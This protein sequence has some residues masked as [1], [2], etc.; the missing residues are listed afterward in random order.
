[1]TSDSVDP[2]PSKRTT[3]ATLIQ[4]LTR[5]LEAVNHDFDAAELAGKCVEQSLRPAASESVSADEAVIERLDVLA[6]V[7]H[8][9]G[10]RTHTAVATVSEALRVL[11][12]GQPLAA[13]DQLGRRWCVFSLGRRGR[14]EVRSIGA[15]FQGS[16]DQEIHLK[17]ATEKDILSLLG[18]QGEDE[19]HW[20]VASSA[21]PNAAATAADSGKAMTNFQR[22]RRLLAPER[23]DI[24]AVVIFAITIGVFNLATPIA[25]QAIVNL[26]AQGGTIQPLVS[27]V[28][29]LALALAFVAVLVGI[30][31]WVV[32]LIQRRLLVRAVA[33]LAARIPR[34]ESHEYDT[35]FGPE[36]INRFFDVL[37]VQKA[38]TKLL[39][40]ALSVLLGVIVGLTVL[41]FYH[42]FLLAFDVVLL[43]VIA[44]IV[45]GPLRRGERTAIL[46]SSAKYKVAAW[47][48]E[49][50]RSPLTFRTSGADTWI[51]EKTDSLS[52]DWLAAREGHFKTL[53]SQIVGALALLVV[54]ST[55]LLAIGGY[56]VLQGSLTL[57]QLVAAELIVSVVVVS[58]AKLGKNMETWYDLMAAVAKVGSLL[59]LPIESSHGEHYAQAKR[60]LSAPTSGDGMSGGQTVGRKLELLGVSYK[61]A[62][63]PTQFDRIDLK[64][65]AGERVLIRGL[66]GASRLAMVDLIWRLRHPSAGVIRLEARD[67]RDLAPDFLRREIAVVSQVEVVHGTVRDNVRLRRPFVLNDDIRDALNCVG[68]R[69]IFAAFDGG[70]DA[71]L[72]PDARILSDDDLRRLMVARALAGDPGVVVIDSGGGSG[73]KFWHAISQVLARKD[74][75]TVIVLTNDG[76]D[77]DG[78]DR[79]I[80][81]DPKAANPRDLTSSAS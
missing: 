66:N 25:V 35:G 18:V 77:A 9:V 3:S 51:N 13:S 81:L 4:V 46:E 55:S 65:Q 39:I 63:S 2:D 42:P 72:H 8:D 50:A 21:T 64:I 7:G 48:E 29:F 41:A 37:T 74:G 20:L 31:T 12:A 22:L 69:E 70:L 49:I 78:Y 30:Q 71:V 79:V 24:V 47:L 44:I 19:V 28:I 53:F 10:L 14:I 76:G 40:D 75:R 62:T 73:S 80:D 6:H 36:R 26:V 43:A 11:Q 23:S 60:Q 38:V 33:D 54:A 59:D 15:D 61:S 67:I 68:L 17:R 56:L 45:F 57:G 1:M 27:V 16:P 34:V 32:E 52:R 58:V 5:L